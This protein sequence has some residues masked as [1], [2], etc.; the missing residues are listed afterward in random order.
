MTEIKTKFIRNQALDC[1]VLAEQFRQKGRVQI[2]N[3]LEPDL[4]QELACFFAQ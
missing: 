3:L 4:A 2:P 1:D